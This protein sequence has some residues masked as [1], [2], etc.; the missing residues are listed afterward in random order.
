[1]ADMLFAIAVLIVSHGMMHVRAVLEIRTSGYCWTEAHEMIKD[2][3]YKS[4]DS[5]SP[6]PGALLSWAPIPIID[7][8]QAERLLNRLKRF[9]MYHIIAQHMYSSSSSH[10]VGIYVD[11]DSGSNS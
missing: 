3:H 2:F 8:A 4:E 6:V 7:D 5:I 9:S 10:V 1:M 11:D